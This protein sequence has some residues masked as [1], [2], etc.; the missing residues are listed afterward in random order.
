MS[1]K[2][3][4]DPVTPDEGENTAIFAILLVAALALAVV[5]LALKAFGIL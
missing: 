1:K 2:N 3:V 5:V 4:T